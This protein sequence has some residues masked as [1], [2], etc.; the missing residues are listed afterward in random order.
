MPVKATFPN[1]PTRAFALR[2]HAV[3]AL[4]HRQFGEALGASERT[5]LRWAA[6]KSSMDISH[7]R[8]LAAL[9]YPRDP[10]LAEEIAAACSETLVSLGIAPPPAAPPARAPLAP[11][12]VADLVVLAVV[13]ACGITPASARAALVA[14]LARL[15][16]LGGDAAKVE[17]ALAAKGA[18]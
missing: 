15:R 5:S 9:V 17:A 18:G 1:R 2:G 4:T 13:E 10:A 16:E 12:H 14:A 8:K 6:G 7:L 3:L 11:E